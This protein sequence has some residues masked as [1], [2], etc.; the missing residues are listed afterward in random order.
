VLASGLNQPQFTATG[1]TF[2]K[3]YEF[4]VESRNSYSYSTLSNTL[5]LLC[6]FV[7][8]PPTTVLSAN[9]NDLVTITWSIPIANGSPIT[10]YK[11]FV[12]DKT[13]TFVQESVEC[14]GNSASVI[15]DR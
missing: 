6:A 5:A 10:G 4:K 1:L 14:N 3:V 15:A 7:P 9:S 2:G 11:I 12:A 13:S 8:D